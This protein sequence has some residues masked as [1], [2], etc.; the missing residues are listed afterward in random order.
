MHTD[1]G[2]YIYIHKPTLAMIFFHICGKENLNKILIF[3]IK[4]TF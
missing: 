3:V 1:T 4:F 2:I